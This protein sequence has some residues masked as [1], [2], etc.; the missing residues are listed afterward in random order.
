M[1]NQ[2]CDSHLCK[3]YDEIIDIIKDIKP[4]YY[5]SAIKTTNLTN[6]HLCNLFIMKKSDFFKYCE[7]IYD[8][9]FEFDRRHNFTSDDDVLNYVKNNTITSNNFFY[10]SRLQGF[11]S[12]RLGN[13]FF[14]NNF[15]KIKII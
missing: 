15:I 7:F 11:L 13:M 1:K 10:Q 8:V 2:F 3:N 6:V 9:L 4:E 12:E 5:E 14:F